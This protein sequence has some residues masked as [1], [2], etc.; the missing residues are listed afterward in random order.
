MIDLEWPAPT[1]Q[2]GRTPIH[3]CAPTAHHLYPGTGG[4]FESKLA[5]RKQHGMTGTPTYKS[6]AAMIRRTKDDPNSPHFRHYFGRGIKVCERW[7]DFRCF[8][9]D[10][11]KRPTEGHSIGRKNNDKGY[12]PGN[13]EWQTKRKQQNERRG[14]RKYDATQQ[15]NAYT[16]QTHTLRQIT[17]LA[18]ASIRN[19]SKTGPEARTPEDIIAAFILWLNKNKRKDTSTA[20]TKP[21][22]KIIQ[23]PKLVSE[24]T[25]VRSARQRPQSS[26][27]P[28][29]DEDMKEL[30]ATFQRAVR[31]VRSRRVGRL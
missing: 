14:V 1:L 23:R 21:A 9:K 20:A 28:H 18:L 5:K 29:D 12:Y 3:L 25:P 19:V 10:M 6:W 8:F 17:Q 30:M 13:C 24:Q 27:D 31:E 4:G 2:C 11:S 22:N 26:W 16:G 7:R 15:I